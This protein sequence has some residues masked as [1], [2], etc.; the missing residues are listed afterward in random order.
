MN[1][2]RF[3]KIC[4]WCMNGPTPGMWWISRTVN[5]GFIKW[6]SENCEIGDFKNKMTR[7]HLGIWGDEYSLVTFRASASTE[8]RV[9]ALLPK[10]RNWSAS[11]KQGSEALWKSCGRYYRTI[12]WTAEVKRRNTGTCQL[13]LWSYLTVLTINMT[14]LCMTLFVIDVNT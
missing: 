5:N 13:P 8:S 10:L 12:S 4:A 11:A 6:L 9:G 7:D 14:C 1:I 2:W 3:G